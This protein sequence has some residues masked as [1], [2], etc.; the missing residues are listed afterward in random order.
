MLEDNATPKATKEKKKKKS[1]ANIENLLSD[2]LYKHKN[3]VYYYTC[4]E[5]W[6]FEIQDLDFLFQYTFPYVDKI[7][8]DHSCY[9]CAIHMSTCMKIN[10]NLP[11]PKKF[12][13]DFLFFNHW[14]TNRYSI[15]NYARSKIPY[16]IYFSS[17]LTL[18][19]IKIPFELPWVLACT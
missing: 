9:F 17:I 4:R 3:E 12:Y 6:Y 16:A 5:K 8:L 19:K 13:Y 15:G 2:K 11:S 18:T 7:A 14:Y 10:V 1:Y